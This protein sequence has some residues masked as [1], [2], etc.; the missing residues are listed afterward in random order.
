MM[1]RATKRT[2]VRRN[3]V[4]LGE[5]R[6]GAGG[7]VEMIE[8]TEYVRNPHAPQLFVNKVGGIYRIDDIIKCTFVLA[9]PGVGGIMQTVEQGSLLWQHHAV[10]EANEAFDWAFKEM[11]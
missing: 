8:F 9:I 6:R 4:P 2:R 1:T 10:I 11:R 3:T 5:V 7:A